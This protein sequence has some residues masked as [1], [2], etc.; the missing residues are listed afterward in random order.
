MSG[1]S[2]SRLLLPFGGASFQPDD[3]GVPDFWFEAKHTG[4]D[5][6][7]TGSSVEVWGKAAYQQ[8]L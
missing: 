2:S 7:T 3:V 1:R 4:D 8:F 5:L 6:Q